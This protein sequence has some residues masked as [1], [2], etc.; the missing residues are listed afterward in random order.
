[1]KITFKNNRL[2]IFIIVVVFLIATLCLCASAVFSNNV[3]Y[4]DDIQSI[5]FC[6]S[7]KTGRYKVSVFNNDSP[8]N[9][10]Y[11]YIMASFVYADGWS[12][13]ATLSSDEG[14]SKVSKFESGQT[15]FFGNSEKLGGTRSPSTI[16]SVAFMDLSEGYYSLIIIIS[17]N[18]EIEKLQYNFYFDCASPNLTI[19][20]NGKILDFVDNDTLYLKDSA[21]SISISAND[22]FLCGLIFTDGNGK[23][24]SFIDDDD[25]D[26]RVSKKDV[27]ATLVQGINTIETWDIVGN[28]IKYVIY[29]D[30][31]SPRIT[32]SN[33]THGNNYYGVDSVVTIKVEDYCSGMDSLAEFYIDDKLIRFSSGTYSCSA[34]ELSAGWHSVTA[35]DLS[36]NTSATRFYVNVVVPTISIVSK[37]GTLVADKSK[38]NEL[39]YFDISDDMEGYRTKVY[40]RVGN[41]WQVLPYWN[42]YTKKVVYY[43][44]RIGYPTT[45]IYNSQ[46]EAENALFTDAAKNLKSLTNWNS[47][48]VGDMPDNELVYA[49][50]GSDYWSFTDEFAKKTFVFFDKRRAETW[51]STYIIRYV[52]NG[53]HFFYEEGA[54]KIEVTDTAYNVTTKYFS[55]DVT[56][57]TISIENYVTVEKAVYYT[58]RTVTAI[59]DDAN[60]EFLFWR[61]NGGAWNKLTDTTFTVNSDGDYQFY[62]MDSFGNSSNVVDLRFFLT[63]DL[64]NVSTIKNSYKQSSWFVVTLPGRIFGDEAGKYSFAS[65]DD[66]L[67]FACC[68]EKEYRCAVVSGGYS[69]VTVS[70]ESVKTIY[71]TR[72]AVEAAILYYAKSYV[73]DKQIYDCKASRNNFFTIMDEFGKTDMS[74]LTMN[75]LTLPSWWNRTEEVVMAPIDFVPRPQGKFASHLELWH[76]ATDSGVMNALQIDIQYNQSFRD[77]LLEANNLYQGYYLYSEKDVCG[78]EQS[79]IL[80]FDLESPTISLSLTR[81]MTEESVL[82]S[83]TLLEA[84]NTF[85]ATSCKLSNLIDNADSIAFIKLEGSMSGIYDDVSQIPTLNRGGQYKITIYDRSYN[86]AMFTIHIAGD[87]PTLYHSSLSNPVK[88]SISILLNDKF[89]AL[90]ELHLFKIGANGE[91]Y[92]LNDDGD[93]KTINVTEL[94]YVLR[95]GGKYTFTLVDVYGRFI[96]LEPFFYCNGL[97]VGTLSCRNGAV[98]NKSVTFSYSSELYILEVYSLN[99]GKTKFSDYTESSSN[100]VT[101]VLFSAAQNINCTFLLF[102][103]N[104]YDESLFIEY[105]FTMDTI[106]PDFSI[107]SIDGAPI[108]QN[109][110]T[111][112]SFLLTWD[113]A[114]ASVRY[115]LGIAANVRTYNKGQLLSAKGLYTFT[116]KDSVGNSAIFTVYLDNICEVKFEGDYK[117]RA[118]GTII[119]NKSIKVIA[120]EDYKVF[121]AESSNGINVELDVAFSANGTY[122]LFFQDLYLNTISY[123][124]IIDGVPPKITLCGV[125]AGKTTS[126]DVIV[127]FDKGVG[128]I[129]SKNE[130]FSCVSEQVVSGH[131]QYVIT[132]IDEFGNESMV[133]FNIDK[134]VDFKT[135]VA[136]GIVTTSRVTLEFGEE[137]KYCSI[138]INGAV[139]V[140]SK[141]VSFVESGAYEINAED[142]FGNSMSLK[143]TIIASKTNDEK[144]VAPKDFEISYVQ[145]SGTILELSNSQ[146]FNYCGDGNYTIALAYLPT[147][148]IY[149]FDIEVDTTKPS[150]KVVISNDGKQVSFSDLSKKVTGILTLNGKEITWSP[151]KILKDVGKYR[152]TIVDELG[153]EA[154]YEF[155]I[156][157]HLNAWAIISI[158]I[159]VLLIGAV[160]FLVVK[161]KRTKAE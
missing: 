19:S 148:D 21:T 77:S 35:R 126:S 52:D 97:P 95:S 61:K 49:I 47:D 3:A 159:V 104:A 53:I 8:L 44:K 155:E 18:K 145:K 105:S 36:G 86:C 70:N 41:D 14:Y 102:M 37:S 120:A 156:V 76:I 137:L 154:V 54:F 29:H 50:V 142:M 85:Y 65:Y 127:I 153:N 92:E 72:E 46:K 101:T 48:V 132:V 2:V 59:G 40:R 124:I 118:D 103:T 81:G 112:Q 23:R 141:Q 150:I 39:V 5:V 56:K 43:D 121:V 33:A 28:I 140:D 96:E 17:K 160:I 24:T 131:G 22:I 152:L 161:A 68:K 11:E 107:A 122:E 158:V 144:F 63:S 111:N 128:L 32:L 110:A 69:Y 115:S 20:K 7:Y 94:D 1:M 123:K 149:A 26:N 6:C 38:V 64:G 146:C 55:V 143:F 57:P 89:N 75:V 109:G 74:A 125:A 62:V 99:N 135:N 83:D 58:N 114:D 90:I 147:S 157:K 136:N 116:I 88:L 78:N 134:Q 106:P 117:L 129:E 15:L 93:G 87:L 100:G 71:A 119:T 139:V 31:V 82:I 151:N 138:T 13:M 79:I 80:Y 66:A 45:S 27:T 16:N 10:R 73:S 4:A 34:S 67:A 51:L 113:E 60:F 12:G 91:Y 130:T 9:G 30:T 133:R 84:R 108:E 42:N 25:V 98:T